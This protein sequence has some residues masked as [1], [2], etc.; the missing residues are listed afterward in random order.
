[1]N[2]NKNKPWG[3]FVFIFLFIILIA[4]VFFFLVKKSEDKKGNDEREVAVKEVA[5]ERQHGWTPF[6]H[7]DSDTWKMLDSASYVLKEKKYVSSDTERDAYLVYKVESGGILRIIQADGRW[8][9]VEVLVEDKVVA[10][11]WIDAH[12]VKKVLLI[13]KESEI[14]D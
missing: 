5:G 13:P 1:M 7:A 8:K 14:R 10:T 2:E 9:E 11:G 6:Y 4:L 12:N 3:I